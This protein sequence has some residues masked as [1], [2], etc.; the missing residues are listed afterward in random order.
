MTDELTRL[1]IK[2]GSDKGDHLGFTPIYDQYFQSIKNEKLN[3][4]EIGI[5]GGPSLKMWYDYFPN[6][7][8][9][10]IDVEDKRQHDNHRVKTYVCD[11]S[12]RK[13]LKEVMSKVGSVDI[14]IDDGCH[15]VSHQ[16]ISLGFLFPYMKDGGQ[17]WLEDL[18]TSDRS[19]WQGKTLYGYDMSIHP[20]QSSVEVVEKYIATKKFESPFLEQEENNYLIHNIKECKLFQLQRTHWGDNKLAYFKK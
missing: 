18:H 20:G 11:Q 9:H 14:I 15:V 7:Q 5:G 8:I 2:Y 6:S 4:L 16:Q 12:N 17:Y 19:V 13:Q 1:A 10:A 3:I